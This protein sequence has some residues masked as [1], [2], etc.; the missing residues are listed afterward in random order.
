M[1]HKVTCAICGKED[2]IEV[3]KGKKVKNKSWDYFGKILLNSD[4]Y[5]KYYYR[6]LTDEK[7]KFLKDNDGWFKTEKHKNPKYIPGTKPK[8][9]EY[10]ECK[11]CV[12]T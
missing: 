10:W 7:G 8:R 1:M 12:N 3:F 9:A 11:D 5:D 6:I 2:R 4:K